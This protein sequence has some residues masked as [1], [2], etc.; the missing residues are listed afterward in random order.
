[1]F[2]ESVSS[3]CGGVVGSSDYEEVTVATYSGRV[4][5]LTKEQ[6]ALQPISEAV[7]SKLAT[8]K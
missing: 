4:L 3:V 1:M 2:N 5:G 8:L 6:V 7:Q